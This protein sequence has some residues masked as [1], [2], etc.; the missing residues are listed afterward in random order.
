MSKS[1]PEA[2]LQDAIQDVITK[3]RSV[4]VFIGPEGSGKWEIV[5]LRGF[6]AQCVDKSIPVIPVLLPEADKVPRELQ[7]L[8][9]LQCVR[10]EDVIED[11]N[12][13]DALVWGITGN[14]PQKTSG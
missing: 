10:F 2:R 13:M 7:F 12:A 8:E 1:L 5:Q 14:R 4:A 11:E 9:E 3:V 6:M